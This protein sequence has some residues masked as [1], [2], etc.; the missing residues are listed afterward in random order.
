MNILHK[1]LK[2]FNVERQNQLN[3]E[4]EKEYERLKEALIGR[5]LNDKDVEEFLYGARERAVNKLRKA[6][7]L[8]DRELIYW[9]MML[10]VYS[11]ITNFL[12]TP[13]VER[14]QAQ[15]QVEGLLNT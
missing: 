6:T 5:K 15:Q 12:E 1:L 11:N 10:D 13:E 14:K 4:E 9:S 7:D 3:S 2:K 8:T